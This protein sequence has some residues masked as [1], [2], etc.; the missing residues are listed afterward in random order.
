MAWDYQKLPLDVL[1][2]LE[3][4]TECALIRTEVNENI[5]KYKKFSDKLKKIQE[6]LEKR[7]K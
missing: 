2:G 1:K 6:E 5:D 3:N 7:G 4:E